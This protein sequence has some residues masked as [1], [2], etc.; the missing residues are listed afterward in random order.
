M[1]SVFCATHPTS[2]VIPVDLMPGLISVD[3]IKSGFI[4]FIQFRPPNA[5]VSVLRF[6]FSRAAAATQ[7]KQ[8]SQVYR[9][10]LLAGLRGCGGC[11]Y[12]VEIG[13]MLPLR[14]EVG[15]VRLIGF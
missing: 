9:S 14:V 6:R 3:L 5:S 8:S 10:D 4:T 15:K 13:A 2:L 12:G 1:A 11:N 7:R